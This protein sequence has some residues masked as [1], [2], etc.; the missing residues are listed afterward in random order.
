LDRGWSSAQVPSVLN[1][2]EGC[3][4]SPDKK[5]VRRNNKKAN[6]PQPNYRSNLDCDHGN[7][8]KE[9]EERYEN[10]NQKQDQPGAAG[11]F[12]EALSVTE[13]RDACPNAKS[14]KADRSK[15][16]T[17]ARRNSGLANVEAEASCDVQPTLKAETHARST[18]P[19][20]VLRV[21][22][23]SLFCKQSKP[24]PFNFTCHSLF[25]RRSFQLVTGLSR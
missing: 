20:G 4:T 18:L 7:L 22:S 17:N 1:V 6:R 13:P 11:T 2:V 16:G 23:K 9:R 19:L 5:V 3:L 14:L 21:P 10:Y 15:T 8:D 25:S 12:S 24:H